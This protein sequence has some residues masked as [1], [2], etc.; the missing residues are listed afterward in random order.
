M[1]VHRAARLALQQGRAQRAGAHGDVPSVVPPGGGDVQRGEVGR[2]LAY[3]LVAR[4][5]VVL[6]DYDALD[7]VA[8]VTHPHELRERHAAGARQLN[9]RIERQERREHVREAKAAVDAAAHRGG[10]AQLHA[11]DIVNGELE[12]I[13]DKRVE[14]GMTLELTQGAH[15]TDA[16]LGLGLL[17]LIE[18]A[19]RKVNRRRHATR[20]QA[21]PDAAAHNLV[22]AV[23]LQ[24]LIGFGRVSNTD[25]GT[26]LEHVLPHLFTC[27][28]PLSVPN[29]GA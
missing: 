21:H 26:E 28:V 16:K 24:E 20:T 19:G 2:S 5:V 17:D 22:V 10:I 23:L 13:V 15:G 29:E 11:H 3:G 25:V 1:L 18:S 6:D 14:P 8:H 27:P 7:H 4:A 9:I 12:D